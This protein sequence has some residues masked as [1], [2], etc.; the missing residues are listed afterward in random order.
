MNEKSTI[1]LSLV[2]WHGHNARHIILL[3]AVFL[4]GEVSYQVAALLVI[5]GEDVE[6]KGLHIVVEGFVVQE[7]LGQ[8]TEVLAV[9]LVGVAIHLEHG[10][11]ATAVDLGSRRVAPGALVEVARQHRPTLGILQAELAQKELG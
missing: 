3:L 7:Q 11:V 8:Q 5:L 1:P 2:L 6:Q 4:F 10:D 9:D